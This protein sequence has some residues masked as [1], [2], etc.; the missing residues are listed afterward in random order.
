M[1]RCHDGSFELIPSYANDGTPE[2]A[3]CC[4]VCHAVLAVGPRSEVCAAL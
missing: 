2:V 3:A 4:A 1:K